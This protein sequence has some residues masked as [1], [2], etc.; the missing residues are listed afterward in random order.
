MLDEDGYPTTADLDRIREWEIK[1]GA[2]L[3]DLWSF[4]RSLWSYPEY[5]CEDN[6]Q[7]SIST[8]GW[9]GN[10]DVIA[11]LQGNW[12]FWLLC[13]QQSR[14]GGHYIFDLVPCVKWTS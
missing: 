12:T 1:S 8:G 3:Q 7:W 4:V 14:R 5:F 13:W 10:E 9:S 2:D 6:G 11:A